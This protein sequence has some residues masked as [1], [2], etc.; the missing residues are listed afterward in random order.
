MPELHSNLVNL[1]E[2]FV[3]NITYKNLFLPLIALLCV[4]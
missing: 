2:N 3:I 4:L 1:V